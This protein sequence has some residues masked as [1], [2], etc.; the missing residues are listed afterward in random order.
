MQACRTQLRRASN[1]ENARANF[2][3]WKCLERNCAFRFPEKDDAKYK[4]T[5]L[6]SSSRLAI[7]SVQVFM[8]ENGGLLLASW[9]VVA[10]ALLFPVRSGTSYPQLLAWAVVGTAVLFKCPTTLQSSGSTS[11]RGKN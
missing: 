4:G 2:S 7:D 11:V 10:E 5:V 6:G 3:A 8:K 1:T 9:M